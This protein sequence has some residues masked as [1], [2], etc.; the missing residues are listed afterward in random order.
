MDLKLTPAEAKSLYDEK[1]RD[2]QKIKDS[3][4]KLKK[5]R[6][7]IYEVN[8]FINNGI[9]II[10]IRRYGDTFHSNYGKIP[11]EISE[12]ML[13]YFGDVNFQA[14]YFRIRS[15][16]LS[17][18]IELLKIIHNCEI[19]ISKGVVRVGKIHFTKNGNFYINNR[20]GYNEDDTYRL[21]DIL[22]EYDL[23]MSSNY[24]EWTNE[25]ATYLR[26]VL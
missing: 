18:T 6:S 10:P 19:T 3:L 7:F 9:S 5:N 17:S 4:D 14:V 8:N 21:Q 26:M 24:Y 13:A 2:F 15:R 20:I 25:E 23:P 22:L 12:L 1:I 16:F 11:S